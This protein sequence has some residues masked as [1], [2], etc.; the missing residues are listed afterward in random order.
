MSPQRSAWHV[1]AATAGL[2]GICLSGCTSPS[3]IIDRG[4]GKPDPALVKRLSDGVGTHFTVGTSRIDHVD[5]LDSATYPIPASLQ[6]DGLTQILGLYQEAFFAG[7]SASDIGGVYVS[8]LFAMTADGSRLVPLDSAA[9]QTYH[10]ERPSGPGWASW[11]KSVKASEAWE[12]AL[13]CLPDG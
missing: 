6:R 1:A 7:T 3:A 8:E 12:K 2:V 9:G 4:C 13:E 11:I 5:V 10:I